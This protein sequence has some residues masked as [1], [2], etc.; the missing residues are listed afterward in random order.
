MT[1]SSFTVA[2]RSRPSPSP[3]HAA[4]ELLNFVIDGPYAVTAA[5][6]TVKG[7]ADIHIN[8]YTSKYHLVGL[9]SEFY[10]RKWFAGFLEALTAVYRHL[11][12]H[13]VATSSFH[14]NGNGATERVDHTVSQM[15]STVV[16]E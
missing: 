8:K 2:R 9:T 12:V 4:R 6:F 10:F 5:E 3:R 16:N 15:L 1:L 14:T 7:T 11:K 13:K